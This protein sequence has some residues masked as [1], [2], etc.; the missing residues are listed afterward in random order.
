MPGIEIK[1][2]IEGME[3][4]QRKLEKD[5]V[6]GSPLKRLLGKAALLVE[7]Q[8]K[9]DSP[10]DTGRLRAS[11]TPEVST[12]VIPLWSKVGTM[13]EYAS[14]VETGKGTPRGVGKIPFFMPA[15]EAMKSKI[16]DILNDAK[17]LIE[18]QWRR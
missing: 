15:F 14:A 11:I 4:L 12:E 17:R 5:T 9:M 18:E 6:L 7:R 16:G 2:E 8:A 13:V 3:E 1:I 10:V